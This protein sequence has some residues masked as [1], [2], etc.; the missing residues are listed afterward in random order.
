M[1]SASCGPAGRHNFGALGRRWPSPR[2]GAAYGAGPA[3]GSPDPSGRRSRCWADA[4]LRRR[5]CRPTGEPGTRSNGGGL[6]NQ[7]PSQHTWSFCVAILCFILEMGMRYTRS[8]VVAIAAAQLPRAVQY[9]FAGRTSPSCFPLAT[10][11]PAPHVH[12]SGTGA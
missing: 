7:S 2:V 8:T 9:V 4:Q 3:L 1:A 5:Y 10:A 12:A 6:R 11:R